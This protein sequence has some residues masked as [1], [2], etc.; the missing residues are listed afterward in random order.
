MWPSWLIATA[1]IPLRR[2]PM[3]K[4]LRQRFLWVAF[5]SV[6]ITLTVIM[7]AINVMNYQNVVRQAD[8]ML[9]MLVANNGK[10]PTPDQPLDPDH[11]PIGPMDEETPF[12]TRFFSVVVDENGKV[13]ETQTSQIAAIDKEKAGQYG[14]QVAKQADTQ[15]FIDTYRYQVSKDSDQAK[16]YF[17]DCR[18][19]LEN[20]HS[21]LQASILVSVLGLIV[22]CAL[23]YFFSKRI[24]APVAESYEKQKRF[25]TDASHELK[26][27][28]AT[29]QA[30]ADVLAMQEDNE[31]IDDI[32]VQV[33]KMTRLTNEMVELARMEEVQDQANFVEFPIS[34]IVNDACQEFTSKAK[35]QEKTIRTDIEPGL[36]YKG[37]SNQI[38]KMM[39]I[40]LDNAIKYSITPSEILVQLHKE[41]RAIVLKVQNKTEGLEQ[42]DLRHLFD[43]FYRKDAS[44]NSKTP[45]YGIGLS[46]VRAIVENHH[47]N[48][49]PSLNDGLFTI[50]IRL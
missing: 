20:F 39:D 33:D 2:K 9:E 38:S 34:D 31:W 15:G 1:D 50:S 44:R 40:L 12:D 42:E 21:F 48:I 46:I 27:P 14:E 11:E 19:S 22:V 24:M 17:L 36:V 10:F 28:L 29:I 3:I 4:Q 43:R 37:D 49:E 23:I 32:H 41:H 7:T 47:G 30:D 8:R 13:K 5:T 35:A 18:R 16:I 25:I 26:T 45:G 6:F